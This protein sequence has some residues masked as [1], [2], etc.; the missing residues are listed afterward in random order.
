M[1][2]DK[3]S[4]CATSRPRA[5]NLSER[6]SDEPRAGVGT[7]LP[8]GAIRLPNGVTSVPAS[9]V[10]LPHR[11]IIDRV[12]FSPN[13]VRS[14]TTPII[15]TFR[16]VDTRGYVVRDALVFLRSTPV[17]T[18]TAPEGR[19]AQNGTVGLTTLPEADFPLRRG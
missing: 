14:R 1:P 15:A 10:T 13:V 17:V 11:L 12:S 2:P 3:S 16:V 9:S 18:T 6:F 5:H 19:S 7:G 8:A 4:R